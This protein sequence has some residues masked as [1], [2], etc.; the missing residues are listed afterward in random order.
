MIVLMDMARRTNLRINN[1][2]GIVFGLC[3]GILLSSWFRKIIL[4]CTS[5][6]KGSCCLN[7]HVNININH[8]PVNIEKS[9]NQQTPAKT[10]GLDLNKYIDPSGKWFVLIGVITAKKFLDSR[11]VAA[12]ETW[13]SSVNGKVLFFS[14][15]GSL[16]SYNIPVVSLK[17]VDD[18]YPPQ[19]KSLEMLGYMYRNHYKNFEWFM[20]VDDDIF[21]KGDRLEKFL[22]SINSSRPHYIG[23]AGF[24]TKEETGQLHLDTHDNY[25]MGGPGIVFSRETLRLVAPNIDDCLNNLLTTHE[26][27]EVGRCVKKFAGIA[28]T[29]AF[30]MQHLFYQNYKEYTG[31]FRTTLKDKA[32]RKA[33]TLHSVK[34]S[35]QQYRIQNY[36]HAVHIQ[37]LQHKELQLQREITDMDQLFGMQQS[38]INQN[39]QGLM[40]SI[41]KYIPENR[42]DVIAWEFISKSVVSHRNMNPRHSFLLPTKYALEDMIVQ[43]LQMVNKNAR[44][45]GRT[46]DYKDLWYGYQRVN[47]LYGADYVLDLLLTYR[48]HKGRKLT[49]PVR[50]HTYLQQ[51]FDEIDLIEDPFT[52]SLPHTDIKYN[53]PFLFRE[54]G[55]GSNSESVNSNKLYETVHFILPLS[56]RLQIFQRFL[57]NYEDIC[58]KTK[59]KSQLHVVLFNNETDTATVDK[60]I[61]MIGSYQKKYGGSNIEIIYA[62]GPFAR[63]RAL[64]L[65]ASQ[66][67]PDSLLF[68]V[69]VDIV[70]SRDILTRL[71][72][73][74][75]QGVQVYY[76]IVFSQ[77]DPEVICGGHTKNCHIDWQNFTG[78]MGYWRSF[79][80]GI[81]SMYGSDLKAVGGFDTTIQGWGKEDVDLYSKFSQSNITVFRSID[82]G[83][84]HA[85]HPV[86]CDS[87]LIDAQYQMCI[88]SKASS[89]GSVRQLA[90][91]IQKRPE[92]YNR[93]VKNDTSKKKR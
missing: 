36:L 57:S 67:G 2:A 93:K 81:A 46:I 74:T 64:D 28:C 15:E 52:S 10:A 47:P 85:F 76:P 55:M 88:G 18:S 37:D 48:K 5:S 60:L 25:C 65:G 38:K 17:D 32:V 27:V 56:G 51:A 61:D 71:R 44:Q 92:I 3:L 16:T 13:A 33:L 1:F 12:F 29:W 40:P 86:F 73:N 82:T 8:L 30:E 14:S 80:Y 23:Q 89:Y 26:D 79:G 91:I 19:K 78:D 9:L 24:G 75:K 45:K 11:A 34:E 63:A 87:N 42:H 50:R 84:V 49:V 66:C 21:V 4:E 68:F 7:Y 54:L 70:L 22:R 72:L 62:D 69:D 6:A 83:M 39:K 41:S 43:V 35:R 77:Y 53:S 58:L 31:S 20:R 90:N 59:E